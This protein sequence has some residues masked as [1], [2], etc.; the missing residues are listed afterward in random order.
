MAIIL[1]T[2]IFTFSYFKTVFLGK[3]SRTSASLWAKKNIPTGSKILSEVYDLGII[4]FNQYFHSITLFN[5]YDLDTDSLTKEDLNQ[6]LA[7]TDYIILPSQRIMKA[8]LTNAK[9]FPISHNFF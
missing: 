8:R 6:A 5:F 7:K 9:Q 2:I 1:V 3:D 4:P